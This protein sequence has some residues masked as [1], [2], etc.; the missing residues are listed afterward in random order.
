MPE[1]TWHD[2]GP[3]E[4]L[5]RHALRSVGVGR[6]KL[7]LSYRDGRFGAIHN[8]CNHAGGPLGEGALEGEFVVCPWH[9]Y[10][11]HRCTGKGEPG[12]EEDA[13]PQF[14]LEE[15]GGH[16]WVRE[17]PVTKRSRLPHPPHALERPLARE[18]GAIRVVGISTT[19]MD[20][21]Y[22]RYSTSD[23][24]LNAALE[25]AGSKLGAQT[26]LLRLSALSFRNCEGYYSKSAK[27]CTWPCSITQMDPGDQ[28]EQVYEALVF[29]SDVIL[30]STPIRWGSASSLYFKMIERMNCIQ[31]QVTLRHRVMLQNKVAAFV[32]TGAQ[33][34]IQAV[35]GQM[36]MFF[37]ELGCH[38]P[39][40]PFIA[41]SRG[42]SAED[43][44]RN[45]AVVR[46]ST[47]LHDAARDLATRSVETS[48][49]LLARA[50]PPPP[51]TLAGRKA[52]RTEP[53]PGASAT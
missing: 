46:A 5:K 47:A 23:D 30:V 3:T 32:I 25:H 37:S 12:F 20:E 21:K 14:A 13:V 7:A 19:A 28:M 43:L 34:N 36:L 45:V 42:W 1:P 38:F 40:F 17:E 52:Q 11:F 10:K 48:R 9:H 41:H 53:E 50:E 26:R 18:P 44:E 31:N 16:L 33:D 29:W 2:L 49:E 8:T 24:L 22:P 4:K 15:R 39:Q 6:L 27:A 51:L 35:A